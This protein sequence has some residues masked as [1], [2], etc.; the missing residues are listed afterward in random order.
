MHTN[1]DPSPRRTH[2]FLVAAPLVIAVAALSTVGQWRVSGDVLG[3][4]GAFEAASDSIALPLR[5]GSQLLVLPGAE[6]VVDEDG[7][8]LERGQIVLSHRALGAV[9]AGGYSLQGWNGAFGVVASPQKVTVIALTTPVLVREGEYRLL[10]PVGAQA[11]LSGPLPSIDDASAWAVSRTPLPLPAYYLREQLALVGDLPDAFVPVRRGEGAA[12]LPSFVDALRLP[13]AKKRAKALA[14]AS[15]LDRLF[16]ALREGDLPAAHSLLLDPA[17]PSVLEGAPE[18]DIA[19]L[20]SLAAQHSV[21]PL[22]MPLLLPHETFRF[23]ASGHP[24]LREH[25]AV[26]E[27]SDLERSTEE[28]MLSALLLPSIDTLPDALSPLVAARWQ[29]TT[30]ALLAEYPEKISMILGAFLPVWADAVNLQAQA[31]F[32]E[33][34][35]RYVDALNV[36]VAPHEA[37]VS[38]EANATLET[39]R[40]LPERMSGVRLGE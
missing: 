36:I 21:L 32:P 23:I 25:A 10:V 29:E 15:L 26:T 13:A 40:T 7:V 17:L 5:D 9:S 18:A 19:Q 31:Q 20:A 16:A 6:V 12:V 24:L 2:R 38:P 28:R 37:V 35:A 8:A 39:V 30:S 34:V 4:E 14:D 27:I 1:T 22:F 3:V 33:R 11:I